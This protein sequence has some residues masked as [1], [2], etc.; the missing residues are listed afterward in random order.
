M[1]LP[2]KKCDIDLTVKECDIDL[3]VKEYAQT[4]KIGIK[5][6]GCF[7]FCDL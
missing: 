1:D 4:G 6:M 2:V 5:T 7:S 3:P